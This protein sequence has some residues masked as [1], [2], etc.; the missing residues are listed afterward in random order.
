MPFG[1][2]AKLCLPLLFLAFPLFSGV[3]D[4]YALILQDQPVAA[5]RGAV[6]PEEESRRASIQSAQA[7]IRTQLAS[8]HVQVTGA[9][10]SLLNAVFVVAT[11]DQLD[12]LRAIPGVKAV[13]KLR[14]RHTH[15]DKA[16]QLIN[17]PAAWSALGGIPNAGLGLKIGII[18][19]GIDQTHPA[20]SDT[21]LPSVAPICSGSDC[22]F[23]NAKVIVARSYVK[24]EAA[25]A[26]PNPAAT[27]SPDDFSPRDHVGHGTAVAM[28]AAGITNT[29]PNGEVLTGIAPKAYLGSYKIYGSDDVNP[30]ATDDALIQ[31]IEDAFNDGMNIVNLSSGFPTLSGTND[32]GAACDNPTGVACDLV[33]Q[34]YQNAVTQGLIITASAGNSGQNDLGNAILTAL[35][36][37]STAPGVIAVA[38]STNSHTFLNGIT[39]NTSGSTQSLAA[40]FS[41]G[42]LPAAPLTA[43]LKDIATVT[44]VLGCTAPPTGSLTGYFAIIQRGTCSFSVKVQNAQTGGAVGVIFT[45]AN[46]TDA[47]NFAPSG[48]NDT[49]IPSVIVSQA[50]GQTLRAAASSNPPATVTIDSSLLVQAAATPNVIADFSSRGPALQNGTVKP[51][52]TAVGTS[53]LMAAENTD[54]DGEVYSPT[55]Y[56]AADGTSFSSPMAAG[57]AALVRQ[58]HPSFT[59]AQ[60]RSALVNYANA[61]VLTEDSGSA[62][63]VSD[64]GGGLLNVAAAVAATVTA[65][66]S[67]VFFGFPKSGA[68]VTAVPVQ[69]A[70]TGGS[71][72][73]LSFSGTTQVTVT[74]ASLALAAGQTGTVNISLPG[75]APTAGNY[76]GQINITGGPAPFHIPFSYIVGSGTAAYIDDLLTD[77]QIGAV[78]QPL[79]EGLAFQIVDQ[80]GAPVAN[81]PVRFAASRGGSIKQPDTVTNQYGIAYTD[82]VLGSTAGTYTFTGSAGGLSYSYEATARAVPTITAAGVVNAASSQAVAGITPGSYISIYGTALADGRYTSTTSTLQPGLQNVSVS[83]DVPSAGLSVPGYLYF[84]NTGQV[85]V[86][87]PWELAGQTSVQMKV[88]ADGIY[89]NVVTVP[90][91]TYAPAIFTYG[92]SL[93]AALDTNGLLIG[94]TNPASR[95]QVVSIFA[96]SLGPVTN[97]PPSGSPAPSSPLATTV[98][99]PVVQIGGVTATVQYSGLAPQF[100]GLYQINVLVP[101]NAAVGSD[102]VTVSIGGVTSPAAFLNVQ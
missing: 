1:P 49:T 91:N 59:P 66:P 62:A 32:T 93:A 39:L 65:N 100:T 42:P 25:G 76:Q 99:V 73:T 21:S 46:A 75:N 83:F 81:A 68:S 38:A 63:S 26:Q 10:Q 84:V 9:A 97:Q 61:T 90:I 36:S 20:F 94:T 37:P 79:P 54:P 41:D 52:V 92:Q 85:N 24:M 89:G 44:D 31:S 17:A 4:H 72:V 34:A 101:A 35:G 18:D 28:V 60:V 77:E 88:S 14:V 3:Y 80:Y 58:A 50:D 7:A 6:S 102:A 64:S 33:A 19:T 87:V 96:N 15:L 22:A 57:A 8:S 48:L 70:N 47:L 86:Q 23:T 12:A 13:V 71:A 30:G 11:P 53:I 67:S 69:I 29:A 27:S 51:D 56:T 98:S 43:P 16:A 95:G 45:L 82:A 2:R 78:G 5:R 40:I 55:R 74:P